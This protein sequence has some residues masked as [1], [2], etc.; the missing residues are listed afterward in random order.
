CVVDNGREEV[1]RLDYREIVRDEI[2]GRVIGHVE[3][4]DQLRRG[5]LSA[6]RTQYLRQRAGA[7]LGPSAGAGGERRQ[8]DL[9][10][11][12]HQSRWYSRR[13]SV[14]SRSEERRVGKECR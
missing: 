12:E 10:A 9:I 4:D 5:L 7:Q 8:P 2:D 14:T 13:W 3:A 11:R 6:H 1:Q